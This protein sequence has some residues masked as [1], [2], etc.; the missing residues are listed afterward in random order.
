MPFT[1]DVADLN[2]RGKLVLLNRI[3]SLMTIYNQ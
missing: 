3:K 2:W 1:L